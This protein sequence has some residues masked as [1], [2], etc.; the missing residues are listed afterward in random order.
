MLTQVIIKVVS[1]GSEIIVKQ[2]P[3]SYVYGFG[4]NLNVRGAFSKIE[5][6]RE[7]LQYQFYEDPPDNR[8]A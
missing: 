1:D 3:K 6:A 2:K 4:H 5:K 7:F 8:V